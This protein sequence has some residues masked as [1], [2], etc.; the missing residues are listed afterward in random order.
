MARAPICCTAVSPFP[1][2][3]VHPRRRASDRPRNRSIF[4]RSNFQQ[5]ASHFP[6]G[7]L[8]SPST[9]T[10][11]AISTSQ[12]FAQAITDTTIAARVLLADIGGGQSSFSVGML[13]KNGGELS[14]ATRPNHLLYFDAIVIAGTLGPYLTELFGDSNANADVS[15]RHPL[16]CHFHFRVGVSSHRNVEWEYRAYY[17]TL[18]VL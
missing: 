9:T 16:R 8:T 2:R 7:H 18:P 11:T 6:T 5:A 10:T 17:P 15:A 12:N 1:A 4:V 14:I 3:D 13:K